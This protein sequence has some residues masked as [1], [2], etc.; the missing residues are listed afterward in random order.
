MISNEIDSYTEVFT[1]G[2]ISGNVRWSV[3]RSD[4][5]ALVM[6]TDAFLADDSGRVWFSLTG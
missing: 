6:F 5:T 2:T 3:S 4:A 1:G